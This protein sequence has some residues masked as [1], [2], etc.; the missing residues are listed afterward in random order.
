MLFPSLM[1]SWQGPLTESAA[2][3]QPLIT[4][5]T[6]SLMWDA[7]NRA[8]DLRH[9]GGQAMNLLQGEIKE[10]FVAAILK[11][12][13]PRHLGHRIICLRA[14]RDRRLR[15]GSPSV[16]NDDASTATSL[17][18]PLPPPALRSS[19]KNGLERSAPWQRVHSN[20][21]LCWSQAISG[22]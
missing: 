6:P 4:K 22:N 15:C 11:R 9:G 20:C 21:R 3:T 12:F 7:V 17:R 10:L 18:E 5:H 2:A 8:E 13:L 1:A 14:V 19:R 16:S